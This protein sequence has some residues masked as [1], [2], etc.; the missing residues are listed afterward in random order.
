M[1]NF[2]G[3]SLVDWRLDTQFDENG[4]RHHQNS[5]GSECWRPLKRL[6]NGTYGDVWQEHCVLGANK[7]TFRAVKQIRRLQPG[8]STLSKREL[9]ALVT[10]SNPDVAEYRNHFVQCL[11]WFDDEHHLYIAMEF[12][13]FG[14]LQQYITCR[15]FPESEAASITSQVAQGLC[16]MHENHFVHRDLKPLNILVSE[17]GPRWHVKLA[18]FGMAKSMDGTL[19]ATQSIGTRG[20]VAPELTEELTTKYTPAVDIWALGAVVFCMRTRIPPFPSTRQLIDYVY[21][22]KIKLIT[23]PLR[24]STGCCID[25]VLGAMA[26]EASSRLTIQQILTHD[27]LSEQSG[28]GLIGST[29]EPTMASTNPW[30]HVDTNAWSSTISKEYS[31]TQQGLFGSWSRRNSSVSFSFNSSPA[32]PLETSREGPRARGSSR[33]PQLKG[34]ATQPSSRGNTSH[35]ITHS[36]MVLPASRVSTSHATSSMSFPAS[37]S[38]ANGSPWGSRHETQKEPANTAEQVPEKK[39]DLYLRE[40]LMLDLGYTEEE[41]EDIL[42]GKYK[43]TKQDKGDRQVNSDSDSD[44]V[45]RPLRASSTHAHDAQHAPYS[46]SAT[47]VVNGDHV[48]SAKTL[49]HASTKKSET[50]F[51]WLRAQRAPKNHNRSESPE[52]IPSPTKYLYKAKAIYTYSANPQDATEISFVKH[53][54]LEV[55]EIGGRWWPARKASGETGIVPSDYLTLL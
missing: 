3:T 38:R 50:M 32:S 13:Y 21:R 26:A 25:F 8:F 34:H 23:G 28:A 14:D 46:D 36:E 19:L 30:G 1:E 2:L 47:T 20:Y 52:E 12:M 44:A 11:G 51:R 41:V 9:E 31:A 40:H 48:L 27:W 6:G 55:S 35:R 53:E 16:Y 49:R 7:N 17:P 42:S 43:K 5:H 18:D 39:R 22:Q 4:D 54:I 24:S 29:T 33:H 15:P 45:F 37:Q 10:F